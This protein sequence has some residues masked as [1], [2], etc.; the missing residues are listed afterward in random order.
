[1]E[2]GQ[3]LHL[4]HTEDR[5]GYRGIA[6]GRCNTLD[7]IRRAHEALRQLR[8]AKGSPLSRREAA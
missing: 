6:H 5:T 8:L 2:E 4:D 1:M 7:G 3:E